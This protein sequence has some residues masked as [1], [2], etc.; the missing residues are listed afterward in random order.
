MDAFVAAAGRIKDADASCVALAGV[1]R[2]P[3]ITDDRKERRI[4]A[5]M[6]PGIELVSTLD[7]LHEASRR[8]GWSEQTKIRGLAGMP[9]S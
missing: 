4:A 5:E 2:C 1:L 6:F 9:R 7:L 3:L 8:L